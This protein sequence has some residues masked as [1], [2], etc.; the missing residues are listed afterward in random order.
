MTTLPTRWIGRAEPLS[1][2]SAVLRETPTT[3]ET[4]S[5]SAPMVAVNNP[6]PRNA[7]TN[8]PVAVA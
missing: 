8:P 6:T 7:E 5:M 1:P 2:C 4:A 3:S